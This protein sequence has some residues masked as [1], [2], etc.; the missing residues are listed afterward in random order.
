MHDVSASLL[1]MLPA[2]PKIFHGRDKEIGA[3]VELLMAQ[4]ARIPILGP[5]GIGKTTLATAVLYHPDIVSKYNKQY[6]VQC[7]TANGTPQLIDAVSFHLGLEPSRQPVDAI[8]HHLSNTGPTI[9]V[10]DNLETVWE[11]TE[12]RRTVEEFLSQL[13]GVPQVALLVSFF[14]QMQH[15]SSSMEQITLRGAERPS[16]VRWNRPFVPPLQPLSQTASRQTFIDIADT[17]SPGDE[18]HL[19]EI[20]ELTG[21]LPLAISLMASVTASEG[22]SDALS[23][24]KY[25]K[26]GLLSEGYG[27]DSNLEKS[28]IISLTSPRMTSQPTALKLLGIL[29]VLP[30]GFRDREILSLHIPMS[31]VLD[32]KSIL[33]RTSLAYIDF[34]GRLKTLSPIREFMRQAYPPDKGLIEPIENYWHKCLA[35]WDTHQQVPGRNLVSQLKENVGNINSLTTYALETEG[36]LGTPV[37]HSMVTLKLFS[38]RM[39]ISDSSRLLPLVPKLIDTSGDRILRWRYL[40]LRLACSG[41]PVPAAEG[42]KLIQ[43]TLE[44]IVSANDRRNQG[45]AC[46]Q[47]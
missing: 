19:D 41:P 14:I 21:Y 9:V 4:P 29:S 34:D 13:S 46:G 20:L 12:N 36:F 10:L 30:D 24:W 26:T 6:F 40:M 18:V 16:G 22:Y 15:R 7:D 39:L 31:S 44:E 27:K 17:P 25:E 8:I 5:G 32:A 23:R 1:P 11:P 38:E 47:L 42:Q 2:K 37:L 28:I 3:V 43:E 45:D 33:L 35:L